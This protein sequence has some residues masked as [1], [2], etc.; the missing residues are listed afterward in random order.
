MTLVKSWWFQILIIGIILFTLADFTLRFTGNVLYFP[1]I[2]VIG[3]FLIPVVFVAYFYQRETRLDRGMHASNILPTL[4]LCA[5]LGG[6]I[7]TLAAG[8]LESR[9]I[10]IQGASS[11]IWVGIIEEFAKLIVPVAIYIIM[12]NRFRTELDGLLFGVASGMAFAALETMGYSLVTLVR[13]QGDLDVLNQTILL[14]GL[15][16][17]AGHAAWTGL[18]TAT[19]WR[20]RERSGKAFTP[21]VVVFF[22]ISAA[23]HSLWNIA[24]LSDNPGVAIPSYIAIAGVSLG[25]LIWRYRQARNTA[26]RARQAE[27]IT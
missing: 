8:V 18:I 19:L 9:T 3:A 7:G 21:A 13:S 4:L 1:T 5:L 25:L 27:V 26:I 23:L 11:M 14:R 12:Q 22:L 2:M 17:P 6:L 20:G 15:V 10:T 24:G 16:S